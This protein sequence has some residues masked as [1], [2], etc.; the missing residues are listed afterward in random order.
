MR[1]LAEI[2][3]PALFLAQTINIALLPELNAAPVPQAPPQSQRQTPF[4]APYP[5]LER[6][7]VNIQDRTGLTLGEAITLALNNNND[8]DISRIDTIFAEYEL[9]AAR[10]V[11]DPAFFSEIFYERSVTPVSSVLGGGVNGAV[12]RREFSGAARL[13]GFTPFWGGSYEIDLSSSR[14]ATDNQFVALNPTFPSALTFT[15]TQPLW[16]GLRF[17]DNRRAIEIAK[18]NLTLTDAQFRQRVIEII[19][20]VEQVYWDLVFAIRNQEVQIE[21]VRQA[22]RQVEN[23]RRMVQEGALA[24]IDIVAAE[25]QAATFEQNVYVAQEEVTRVENTLKTLMLP[26]RRNALWSRA[27]LPTTP[28]SLTPPR[29][30]LGDAVSSALANRPE[31]QQLQASA[32]INQINTRY[33]R[34]QTHPQIDL[35]A[36]YTSTSLGGT[37]T[38]TILNPINQGESDLERRVNELSTLAGLPPLPQ[39]DPAVFPPALIGGFGQSFI[40]LFAF[41]FS[42]TRVGLRFSL[43]I[44]NRTAKAQLGRSL[45]EATRITNQ[46]E[47]LEQVIEAEVRNAIQAVRSNE[48]RL[49]AASAERSSAELQYDAEQHRFQAGL[50]TVFLVLQRQTDLQSARGRELRAQT[51]LNKAIAELQRVTG[52][53]LTAHNI[54]LQG[55]PGQQ[56]RCGINTLSS[57]A[58][59]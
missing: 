59:K 19:T 47:Q 38:P 50:S 53:T 58:C 45:A 49:A 12:K 26:D 34:N 35:F 48:A 16:R 14:L 56:P 55:G 25:T 23:N 32:E 13:G 3:V 24:P 40:D 30:S 4:P 28:A 57:T 31:L 39:P 6:V 41:R 17:D 36:L 1:K 44:F 46:R 43:P 5:S 2:L 29:I 7:G 27:L 54:T 42:T 21:A 51:D 8:I 22:Q 33:F 10:G 20:Q 52:V 18:K 11:Y 37:P 15:Y 9:S